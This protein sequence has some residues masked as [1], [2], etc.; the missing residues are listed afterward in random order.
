M[1]NY[2][3]STNSTNYSTAIM[4]LYKNMKAIIPLFSND[5]DFFDIVTRVLQGDT[6]APYL[7]L[8][9]SIDQLRGNY[10]TLK[11]SRSR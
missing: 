5:N 3:S 2:I 11:K 8:Q 4:M 9:V 10:L 1:S 6:L 7:L